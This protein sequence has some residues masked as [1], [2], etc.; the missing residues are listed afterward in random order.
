MDIL[1]TCSKFGQRKR[2]WDRN[3]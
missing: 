3:R 2:E 1:W